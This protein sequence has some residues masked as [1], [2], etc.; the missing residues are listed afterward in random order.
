[1]SRIRSV[2][3]GLFTDDDFMELTKEA[4]LAAVLV[5]GLWCIADDQG[6][7]AWKP[8]TIKAQ[9]LPAANVDMA[10]LLAVLER[11]R[12]IARFTV[13]GKEYGA[14]RNFRKWQRPQKP[15]AIHPLPEEY[16][17]WVGLPPSEAAPVADQSGSATGKSQQRYE[18]GG[19]GR[20]VE[21]GEK[22][23]TKEEERAPVGATPSPTSEPIPTAKPVRRKA[24]TPWPEGF[25]PSL[26]VGLREGLPLE[27]CRRE[28][29]KCRDWALSNGIVKADWQRTVDN[30]FRRAAEALRDR[31]LNIPAVL[32]RRPHQPAALMDPSR[33]AGLAEQARQNRIRE[34]LED[35]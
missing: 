11:R 17:S 24:K 32:D 16:R 33:L 14:I 19:V 3:P 8:N 30:W 21:V 23:E 35:A 27:E 18:V 29:E 34:G 15:T 5:P 7:F 4:P 28:V 25:E 20:R 31:A 9:V 2:H 26:D 12:F 6:V 10:E 22:K 13:A 1:M